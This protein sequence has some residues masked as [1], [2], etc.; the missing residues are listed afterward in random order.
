MKK[1]QGRS[2][3]LT[4]L[5][6]GFV[7]LFAV[8]CGDSENFV[9]TGNNNP[10]NPGQTGNLVFNFVQAQD[11]VPVGTTTLRFDF[12]TSDTPSQ[13]TY[14]FTVPR[15]FA[16]QI[17]IEDVP[18][19][20][21]S[22]VVTAFGANNQPLAVL[23]G[24]VNVVL[25]ATTPVD[26][27]F[28]SNP[29]FN[30]LSLTPD[31]IILSPANSSQTVT[32]TANFDTSAVLG[33]G[34]DFDVTVPNEDVDFTLVEATGNSSAT[35]N[36][37][38]AGLVT[39]VTYGQNATLNAEY[40]AFGTT[41]DAD[42]LVRTVEL[43]GSIIEEP[44]AMGFEV[45]YTPGGV[46]TGWYST[47]FCDSN[48]NVLTGVNQGANTVY[49]LANNATGVVVDPATG[50]FTTSASTSGPIVVRATWTDGRAQNADGSGG[51]GTS[52]SIDYTFQ[53]E[54]PN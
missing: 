19:D 11:V 21:Q 18:V 7:S 41:L 4:L 45:P 37:T 15:A 49:E 22:V 26:L 53:Q 12:F 20:I 46:F 38:S 17:I 13:A 2:A 10:V 5:V 52:F 33:Q 44:A 30:A 14:S 9:F 35:A 31:P 50:M 23:T 24:D 34:T 54:P 32:V 51:T 16:S 36:V 25:G 42:A 27:V 6:V 8:G 1:F 40:T 3:L 39:A 28:N 43:K 29:S 48:G 47:R